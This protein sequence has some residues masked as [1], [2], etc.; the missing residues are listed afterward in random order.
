MDTIATLTLSEEEVFDLIGYEQPA[1][2]V[3]R[4]RE[5][6]FWLTWRHLK[7]GRCIV[8]RAHYLAVCAGA[9]P[10]A[11]EMPEKRPQVR[12]PPD[13]KPRAKRDVDARPAPQ[14][15]ATR[16]AKS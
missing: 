10:Q 11:D 14:P 8:P 13:R 9:K 4:M 5:L 2:Q 15:R 6:G 3:K 7:S 16:G 1:T 12:P